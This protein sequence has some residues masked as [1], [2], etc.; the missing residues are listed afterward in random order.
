MGITYSDGIL[1]QLGLSGKDGVNGPSD[2]L[3][4]ITVTST[5]YTTVC[6]C[7]TGVLSLPT[8]LT[9]FPTSSGFEYSSASLVS[10]TTSSYSLGQSSLT[11]EESGA[12]STYSP[13]V[14]SH[15]S[16]PSQSF[17][18]SSSAVNQNSSSSSRYIHGSTETSIPSV[19]G[20]TSSPC[21]NT[22]VGSTHIPSGFQSSSVIRPSASSTPAQSIGPQYLSSTILSQTSAAYASTGL[23]GSFQLSSSSSVPIRSS[24]S[25]RITPS[26][27]V[28]S[29]S[30][31]P[32]PSSTQTP[33]ILYV[34]PSQLV[35][36]RQT[37]NS[38]VLIGS[39]SL[40]A[41]CANADVFH[42]DG[43]SL[44]DGDFLVSTNPGVLQTK[45]IGSQI[46]GTI[47]GSFSVAKN[48]L[49]WTNDAFPAGQALFCVSDD[50]VYA[51][52]DG[53]LP[54]GCTQVSIAAVPYSSICSGGTASSSFHPIT[55]SPTSTATSIPTCAAGSDP[56]LSTTVLPALD[57]NIDL[58]S[59]LNL[60]PSMY[61]TLYYAQP[62][63]ST[64]VQVVYTMLYSQVTLENSQNIDT[65]TCSGGNTMT[66]VTKTKVAYNIINQWPQSDLILI[67]NTASC[68]SASQRGVYT[69]TSY[70]TD[71][72]NLTITLKISAAT[73]TDV[74]ETMQISYGTGDTNSP[75]SIS[76]TPSCSAPIA[77][78]TSLGSATSTDVSYVDLTPEEKNI[79]AYLTKNNTYDDNGNIAVTM[80]AS[81]S[82]LTAPSYNP[83]SNSS[84]QA[85]LED[86]LQT[87]GL[88]SPD[89]LWHKTANN[90]AGHCSNG[91]YVPPTTVFTKRDLPLIQHNAATAKD[92][93]RVLAKRS[94]DINDSKWWKYLWEGGCNDIVDEIIKA[95]NKEAGEIVELICAMKELYDDVDE[96]YQNR[97]AIKCVF[98]GCYLEE[99]IATYW[100]YTYSWTADFDIPPQTIVS[101]RVG[102][103][104]CVDCSLSFSEVQFVGSVM[105][106][107]KTGAVESAYM[108][109]TMSWTA[110][111]VMSLDT[112]GAWSNEWDYTFS[113]LNFNNPITV[114][115]EFTITPSM[116]YSLGVQWSTTDA[117]S[118]TGGASMSVNSGSMYL[119]FKESTATQISN[120]SPHVQYTYPVFTTA[121]TVSFIPI[122]RSSLSIA[123]EIQNQPYKAQPI[124]I[125]TASAVGFNAAL[126]ETDGGACPAGQLMMTS[127]TDV[128]SN[129]SFSGGPSQVLSNTGD[130]AGQ[131]KCFAVPND[132]PTVDEVNSLRSQGAAFCTSYLSYT[133]PTKVAYAVTTTTGPSTTHIT[134][135]TTISTSS[136]V[137]VF[138][139][140]TSVFVQTTTVN[141]TSY[142][143]ASGSQSL[144]DSYM[145]KRA[146]ETAAP[147]RVNNNPIKPTQPPAAHQLL[148][149]TIT[150][151]P[152]FVSTWDASKLSLGCS[153]VATGTVTT[154]FYSSTTTAYSGVVTSTAYSTVDVLG[155]LYTNTFER[156]V[157]SYTATTI[158]GATTATATATTA[159]S[160]P[161]QTQVSCFTITGTG[162]DH[163]NGKQLYM[164]DGQASPVWG[165]WGAGYELA[166]FYLTCSGDLVALPSMKVLSTAADMWIEFGNFTS[167]SSPTNQRCIQ[168][169]AAGTLSCGA[170]WYAMKPVATTINDFRAFSG[171][172][173]PIWSDGS[174]NDILTPITLT[175]NNATCPCQ[176]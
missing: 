17:V 123:V 132:I 1:S 33:L 53:N 87:A 92:S 168:D 112:T 72:S 6:P 34:E 4:T 48:M 22:I 103:V 82:N 21:T 172:W 175:Y 54:S 101:S 170:G 65:V 11:P 174:N 111:L 176:Y 102:T 161:L 117:V 52:F 108:T 75:S 171:Y 163:I 36:K 50:I 146:L 127:Y 78:T 94:G 142:V 39:G 116:I 51:V 147:M 10:I 88:P 73:W 105:I 165:G 166:T 138:P 156:V 30:A 28:R 97:D 9:S 70:T 46:P 173:Q 137:Y 13:S 131:M 86:A 164:S 158:T 31:I 44:Y 26:Q 90:L 12:A 63:G 151:T 121:A 84:E 157:V 15:S 8:E 130:V 152:A 40:T 62:Y 38:A 3:W 109:P 95:I 99:T 41:S 114:P 60:S 160:C 76:Y 96:A 133:P 43:T 155:K 93:R 55:P 42:V 59:L 144:G 154:T 19:S 169:T 24:S 89:S 148:A 153:Q 68:N 80:P 18:S 145:R 119:D 25:A 110:D 35:R 106:T 77:T 23:S 61:A 124:Y 141:P 58:S 139:T 159:S 115:G 126:I 16:R 136:T 29:S 167:S 129:V 83:A 20:Y 143:T 49:A 91:V 74:S 5:S 27:T 118:F 85:A 125:N 107:T 98:T 71:E 2:K 149:R 7:T 113:T 64:I 150:S 135:P 100:N 66:I 120:W 140:I 134:L 122:M 37:Y 162:P 104:K 14:T 69:V 57:P 56:E 128:S 32:H 81:T 67:T 45:F 47:S 79:V